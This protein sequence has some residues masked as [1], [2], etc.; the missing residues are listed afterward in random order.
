MRRSE[1]IRVLLVSAGGI[2]GTYLIKHLCKNKRLSLIGCDMKEYIPLMNRLE[3]FYCVPRV[4]EPNYFDQIQEIIEKEEIDVIVPI[5]SYDM[6]VYSAKPF[7]NVYKDKMLIMPLEN[8]LCYHDKKKCSLHLKEIGI[9]S[10][11]LY[12]EHEIKYPAFL[13]PI[14]GSGSKYVSKLDNEDDLKYWIKKV[15]DHVI[16]EYIEGDEYTVDCLFDRNGICYGYNARKRIAT[17]GGG[18]T[19]CMNHRDEKLRIIIAKLE[20]T[21]ELIGAVNFQYKYR[22]GKICIFDFN[23]RFASGGLPL[24]VESGFDIPNLLIKLVLEEKIQPYKIKKQSSEKVMMRYYEEEFI[25]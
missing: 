18:A 13:K 1:K 16:F 19:I 20:E 2:T 7:Y 21:K 25:D 23:T 24:T 5:T 4:T 12:S 10:P 3:K 17:I 8:V 6:L 11:E 14:A 15:P 22:N 9:C